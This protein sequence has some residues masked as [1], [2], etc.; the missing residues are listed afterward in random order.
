MDNLKLYKLFRIIMGFAFIIM[1]PLLIFNYHLWNLLTKFYVITAV[2]FL[3]YRFTA[4]FYAEYKPAPDYGLSDEPYSILIPVKNEEKNLFIKTIQTIVEQKGKKEILIGDDCSDN[5]VEDLLKKY[6]LLYHNVKI[7][8]ANENIGKKA[9]QVYLLKKAKYDLIINI[10]SD[11]VLGDNITTQKLIAPL[12][13]RKVGLTNGGLSIFD[14]RKSFLNRA[15]SI[16]YYCANQIGRR[17]WGNFGINPV[18][19]GQT[20][21]IRK[22]YFMPFIDEYSNKKFLGQ[23]IN[24]GEDRLMT[25]IFLREGYKS[26]Y[27]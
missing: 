1:I 23:K 24:F 5:K 21:A 6:P 22:S 11:V 27:V 8:R 10:D 19:S 4:W 7:Y 26:V 12:K 2:I 17:S 16:M 14:P 9:M 20:L 13:N 15:Q 18:A 3:L 25:N